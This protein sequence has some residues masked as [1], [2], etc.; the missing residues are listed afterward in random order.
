MGG[1]CEGCLD[2]AFG[3]FPLTPTLSPRERG[4]QRLRVRGGDA[5]WLAA[6]L[7]TILPLPWGEGRGENSPKMFVL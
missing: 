1:E 2:I 3:P 6:G 5:R 4:R 7:D